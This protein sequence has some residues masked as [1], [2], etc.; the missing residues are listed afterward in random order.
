MSLTCIKGRIQSRGSWSTPIASQ[1]ASLKM[2]QSSP[3]A[4]RPLNNKKKPPTMMFSLKTSVTLERSFHPRDASQ[5]LPCASSSSAQ[6][7]VAEGNSTT[8][9]DGGWWTVEVQE[10]HPQIPS[11]AAKVNIHQ[12]IQYQ[13]FQYLAPQTLKPL[14]KHKPRSSLLAVQ[15]QNV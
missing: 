2:K 3:T 6:R 7:A 11:A 12:G 10:K 14:Q 15:I 5:C 4:D 9:G 13:S 8:W 1:A